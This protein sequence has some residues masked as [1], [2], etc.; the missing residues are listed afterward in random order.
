[1]SEFGEKD[2]S[3]L[4]EALG[5]SYEIGFNSP[6]TV[7]A[8][9]PSNWTL[10]GYVKFKGPRSKRCAVFIYEKNSHVRR[11]SSEVVILDRKS[12]YSEK[13][14]TADELSRVRNEIASDAV[15]RI[16]KGCT[17]KVSKTRKITVPGSSCVDELILR[18]A[19][20]NVG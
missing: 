19:V 4:A 5:L 17:V 13:E 10:Y 3:R 8:S 1:M 7:L 12:F 16:L 11:F 15:A 20:A 6:K 9:W 14:L 18:L 2:L